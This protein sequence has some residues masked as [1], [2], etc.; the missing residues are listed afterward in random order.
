MANGLSGSLHVD[1]DSKVGREH[2]DGV[3]RS[4]LG[5]GVGK[6]RVVIPW[7]LAIFASEAAY[8]W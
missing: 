4:R 1:E 3:E 6:G 7:H 5:S 2:G 8:D